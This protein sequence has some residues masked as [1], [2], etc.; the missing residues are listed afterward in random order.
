MNFLQFISKRWLGYIIWIGNFVNLKLSSTLK[1]IQD[2]SNPS[3][4]KNPTWGACG[5]DGLNANP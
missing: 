4:H 2:S 3:T 1:I 5:V